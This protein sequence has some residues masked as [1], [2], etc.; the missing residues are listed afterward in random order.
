[1]RPEEKKKWGEKQGQKSGP[2]GKTTKRWYGGRKEEQKLGRQ[3]KKFA[4]PAVAGGSNHRGVPRLNTGQRQTVTKSIGK[5]NTPTAKHKAPCNG[6]HLNA[7]TQ[8][9]VFPRDRT[10]DHWGQSGEK[11]KKVGG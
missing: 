11:K 1:V 8:G 5:E 10:R 4:Q 9:K 3:T 6:G 7:K 2:V